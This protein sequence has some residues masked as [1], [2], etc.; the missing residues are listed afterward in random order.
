MII[1]FILTEDTSLPMVWT[2]K[3]T[4]LMLLLLLI[5][6]I[7]IIIFRRKE[8]EDKEDKGEY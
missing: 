3:Y 4:I 2:D 5:H 8:K 1:I 7:V 6:I